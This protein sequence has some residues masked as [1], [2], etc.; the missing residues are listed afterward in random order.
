M[1]AILHVIRCFEDKNIVHVDGSIDPVRDKEIIDTELLLK[2]I[3]T[4]EKKLDKYKKSAK[5]GNKEDLKKAE[6]A[7]KNL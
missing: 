2:D 5:S 4:A 7:Q 6:Y 3:E 1:D